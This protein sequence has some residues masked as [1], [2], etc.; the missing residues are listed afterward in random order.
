LAGARPQTPLGSSQRSPDPLTGFEG[1]LLLR[2][3][4]GTGGKGR[5]GKG[6]GEE[7]EEKGKEGEGGGRKGRG[8]L[9]H[10][11]LGMNAPGDKRH[12]FLLYRLTP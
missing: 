6:E 4:K 8:R 5:E 12:S 3:G 10:G 9:R 11:F 2:E 1:V 7:K